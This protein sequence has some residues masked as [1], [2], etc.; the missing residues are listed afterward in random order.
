MATVGE[1]VGFVK[2]ADESP[3]DG[4][5][6]GS[7]NF[8]RQGEKKFKVLCQDFY[9]HVTHF[10]LPYLS[11]DSASSSPSTNSSSSHDGQLMYHM[12]QLSSLFNTFQH[13]RNNSRP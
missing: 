1:G 2:C 4:E 8:F 13:R 6:I 5:C 9:T 11:S 7:V 3:S 10:E 12:S